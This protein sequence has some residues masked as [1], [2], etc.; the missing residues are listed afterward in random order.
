MSEPLRVGPW[1]CPKCMEIAPYPPNHRCQPIKIDADIADELRRGQKREIEEAMG[2]K[3]DSTGYVQIPA[4]IV[5]Q[6]KRDL[7]AARRDRIV[8]AAEKIASAVATLRG[9]TVLHDSDDGGTCS[10]CCARC[11]AVMNKHN[12]E[13]ALLAAVREGREG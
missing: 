1:R 2:A 7:A 13:T 11:T 9:V 6:L 8:A 3:P 5:S 4:G 10:S 12:A